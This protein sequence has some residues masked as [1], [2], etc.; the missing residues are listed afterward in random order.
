[1]PLSVIIVNYRSA[2]YVA[3]C[4][5]SAFEFASAKS[6]EWIVVDNAS[7][8][9]SQQKI[10]HEFS[11]VKWIQMDY[12]A[13]FARANNEAMRRAAG[14]IFLLLNADTIVINNAIERCYNKFINTNHVACG[15]QLLFK[16]GS[17]QISGSFFM[18]GGINH[19]L[20]LPYWGGF[21]K[22]VA[23]FLHTKK[24]SIEVA[25]AEEKVEWISGAFLMVKKNAVDKAGMMDEDFFLYS[26]EIEWCGRLMKTGELYIYGDIRMI[27]LM[28]EIIQ[29]ATRGKDKT[30]QYLFDR[31]GLQLIVS[32]H[33]RIRKQYGV[34]WFIF[35][36][37]NYTWGV[38]VFF[39]CSFFYNLFHFKNPF[40]DFSNAWG[41]ARNVARVWLLAPVI[42]RNKPHFYKML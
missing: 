34:A 16:D 39:V 26:E 18:K 22:T 10:T 42:I 25:S 30:Y 29:D 17:T 28:G 19:L 9:D 15:V 41:L 8:D 1:L 13:G 7:G 6:F 4:L 38:P 23:G 31:K 12:N 36:L 27:H 3:A 24:P 33:V 11:F 2:N 5:R 40:K 21:L 20:P 35:Q 14:D 37:A 32:N